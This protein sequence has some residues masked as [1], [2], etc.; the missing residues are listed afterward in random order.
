MFSIK[1]Y[2]AY[3][4]KSFRLPVEVVKNLERIASSK[5]ISVNNL[6]LQMIEFCLN[7]LESSEEKVPL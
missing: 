5:N 2:D 1:S 6:V 4:N 3:V 7:D